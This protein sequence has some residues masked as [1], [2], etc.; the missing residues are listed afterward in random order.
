MNLKKSNNGNLQYLQI[1]VIIAA[2]VMLE[3]QEV[4]ILLGVNTV[5]RDQEIGLY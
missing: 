2:H 5:H 4:K 3:V 1:N